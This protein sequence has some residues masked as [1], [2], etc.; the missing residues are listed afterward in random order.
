MPDLLVSLG[1]WTV[2][3]AVALKLTD[4]MWSALLAAGGACVL[5]GLLLALGERR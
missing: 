3:V 2:A 4:E 1:V 5:L